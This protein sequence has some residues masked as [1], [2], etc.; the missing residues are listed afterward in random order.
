MPLPKVAIVGRPNVG[1]SSIFNWLLD[2]R[3][4]I[5]DP[6]SGVTRDRVGNILEHADRHF[7]L[8]DTGGMGVEDRDG[9]TAEIERQISIAIREAAMV[10]FVVDAQ[11]GMAPLDDIVMARLRGLSKPVLCVANK[12]DNN[13][14]LFQAEAEFHRFGLPLLGV[15]VAANVHRHELLA[16]LV[17]SLPDAPASVPQQVMKIAAVGKRNVGKSTFINCLAN[18]NRMIVSEVPGTT[19]DSVDVYFEHNNKSF[20]AIDTAGLRK[21]KSLADSIEFYSYARA[22][23]TIRRA[24][25]VLLFIDSTARVSMVDKQLARYILDQ[26]KPCV[27]VVNKWDLTQKRVFTENFGEYLDRVL[28]GM[29]FAPR[30]FITAKTGRNVRRLI[31]VCQGLF[32]QANTRVTTGEL[33]RVINDALTRQPPPARENRRARIYF[34]TQVDVAPPTIILFCNDPKLFGQSYQRYLLNFCRDAL[35]FSEVPIKILLRRR[36]QTVTESADELRDLGELNELELQQRIHDF[37]LTD[38]GDNNLPSEETRPE[39]QDQPDENPRTDDNP[40]SNLLASQ[41]MLALEVSSTS[42]QG[43]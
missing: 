35:P 10:L 17:Q 20:I 40:P 38:H 41:G 27:V 33:N 25:V 16:A 4:A 24:D 13:K 29:P 28:V 8:I 26:H 31:D 22:Q 32:T 19:R 11:A 2:K 1:K 21:K 23:Q 15:S 14:Y 6:T 7:E 3:V 34:A 5:V 42:G 36:G 37:D 18:D 39:E 9:L 30:A 43:A 12:C